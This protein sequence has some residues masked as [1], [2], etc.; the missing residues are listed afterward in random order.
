M[1]SG[2][3]EV[4]EVEETPGEVGKCMTRCGE[5]EDVEG[6]EGGFSTP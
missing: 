6:G 1:V 3:G 5:V 2:G 4:D